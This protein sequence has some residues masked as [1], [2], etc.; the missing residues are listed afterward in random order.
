MKPT[1]SSK[2]SS[3]PPYLFVRLH[4]LKL[5]AQAAGHDIIDLGQGSPDLP[6]PPNV[7]AALKRAIDQPWTHRYPQTQGP[8]QLRVAIADWYQ[9][10]FGVTLDPES[11]VLPL[12][13]SKEGLAHLFMA[14]LEPGQGVLV[15]NPCYPV[16]Y[17]GVILAG[18]KAHL[19][20]LR[21]KLGFKPDLGAIPAAEAEGS[22]VL[23]LNYP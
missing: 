11:E 14:L 15:P 22:K 2:L 23:L 4:A 18:G 8:P 19:M 21:E 13:G 10:R 16:H 12:V 17:N 6:S 3:L 20:P 1:P 7:V 5:Q 9:R